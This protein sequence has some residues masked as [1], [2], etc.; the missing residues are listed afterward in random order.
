M[1]AHHICRI[2]QGMYLNR[3]M[4]CTIDGMHH[5]AWMSPILQ[6]RARDHCNICPASIGDSTSAVA[7]EY[8]PSWRIHACFLPRMSTCKAG[9]SRQPLTHSSITGGVHEL[10]RLWRAHACQHHGCCYLSCQPEQARASCVDSCGAISDCP[11]GTC[12]SYRAIRSCSSGT[13]RDLNIVK[14][15][16]PGTAW[17]R[18]GGRPGWT[19]G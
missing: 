15:S 6:R 17:A 2:T 18:V 11:G 14:I 4:H 9:C 1:P 13:I 7:A 8:A 19:R 3:L 16:S 10:C 12:C 5:I